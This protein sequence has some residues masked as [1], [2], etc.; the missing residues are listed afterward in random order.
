MPRVVNLSLGEQGYEPHP[1]LATHSV[2]KANTRV[3]DG[4][5]YP[6]RAIVANCSRAT[7]E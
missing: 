3:I 5:Q 7:A 6:Q 1:L 4:R 2:N